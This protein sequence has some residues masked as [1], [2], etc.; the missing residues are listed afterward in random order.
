MKKHVIL[1]I[2]LALHSLA[3]YA[4]ESDAVFCF[5]SGRST[6]NE[7]YPDLRF[8]FTPR[9]VTDSCAIGMFADIGKRNYRINGTIGYFFND[10][11]RMKISS[12]YLVQKIGYNFCTG[13]THQW[14]QQGA[15]G[16]AYQYLF[17]EPWI[18]NLEFSG[19]VAYSPGHTLHELECIDGAE[20][21]RYIAGS[22]TVGVAIGTTLQP[23]EC[24]VFKI[25]WNYDRLKY[26]QRFHH[27]FYL[28]GSGVS[29]ELNQQLLC[30]LNLDLKAEFR[31]PY[32]YYKVLLNWNPPILN[33]D[34]SDLLPAN[35]NIGYFWEYTHGKHKLPYVT[36]TGIEISYDLCSKRSSPKP[37][38]ATYWPAYADEHGTYA[39]LFE[40][41]CSPSAD[42]V[43]CELAS[44]IYEPAVFFPIV[45]AVL[46]QR[47]ENP[48]YVPVSFSIPDQIV[49][50]IGGYVLDVTTYFVTI[51]DEPYSFSVSGLPNGSIDPRT[52]LI[53]GI[54]PTD[55]NVYEVTIT[56]SSSCGSTSET[57]DVLYL[58]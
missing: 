42:E 53:G 49:S 43:S 21:S 38:N 24:G 19:Y 26:R 25:V 14:V 51:P 20:I 34:C 10:F 4:S 2:L 28:M 3:A 13:R 18:S 48:C 55:G 50:G 7:F 44:W 5:N 29:L 9:A 35:W 47:V 56:A 57:F 31:R 52:G 30:N 22:N 46:D 1:A 17:N 6:D 45:L 37:N 27:N 54:N 16:I 11:L 23:W 58:P 36:T 33:A 41:P 8:H 39:P 32:N 15:A 40:V 12:E